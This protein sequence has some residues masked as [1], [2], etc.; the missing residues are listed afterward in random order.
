MRPEENDEHENA[1][2]GD[3]MNETKIEIGCDCGDH[4]T[5]TCVTHYPFT[6]MLVCPKGH[7][8]MNVRL[9]HDLSSCPCKGRDSGYPDGEACDETYSESHVLEVPATDPEVKPTTA[10][11]YDPAKV[12]FSWDGKTMS[13]RE[14]IEALSK[15]ARETLIQLALDNLSDWEESHIKELV[16]A[17]L[18]YTSKEFTGIHPAVHMEVCQWCSD[19]TD[20]KAMTT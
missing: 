8:W 6:H 1:K 4:Q 19:N 9:P 17:G 3:D 16:D 5:H 7:R 12:V 2:D 14:D 10:K 15:P 18:I 20:E 11:M 13:I